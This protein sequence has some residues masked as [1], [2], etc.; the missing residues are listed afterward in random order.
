MIESNPRS[1]SLTHLLDTPK[2][3]WLTE[4]SDTL[5]ADLKAWEKSFAA[6]H[7]GR[8]AGRADIKYHVDI[9]KKYKE[10]NRVRDVLAGK[11]SAAASATSSSPAPKKRNAIGRPSAVEH[12]PHRRQSFTGT[13]TQASTPRKRSGNSQI[14]HPSNIDP[15]DVPTAVSAS[16]HTATKLYTFRQVIGPTPQ[17]D[18]KALGLFDLISTSGSSHAATPSSRKRKAD[19]L[20]EVHR[21]VVKTPSRKI[22][23][24]A[25]KE[26]RQQDLLAH[27][28]HESDENDA[29]DELGQV[30]RRHSRTPASEGKK[31]LLSQF[32]AT[33]TAA[34]FASD[35]ETSESRSK[36]GQAD[37]LDK[38]P[39]RTS[40][41]QNRASG[42]FITPPHEKLPRVPLQTGVDTTPSFLKRPSFSQ[43]LLSASSK[44][45]TALLS[46]SV[47]APYHK[48]SA[49]AAATATV[50][51][52]TSPSAVRQRGPRSLR[53]A[54]GRSLSQIMHN[55]RKM[56]D[57]QFE[58]DEEA[59]RDIE[60]GQGGEVRNVLV[61]DS[62]QQAPPPGVPLPDNGE[63]LGADDQA[64]AEEGQRV[65]KKKGQKRT[66]RRVNMRPSVAKPVEVP[67]WD[68]DMSD[69]DGVEYEEAGGE[70]ESEDELTAGVEETQFAPLPPDEL[71]RAGQRSMARKSI[72]TANEASQADDDD[73]FIAHPPPKTQTKKTKTKSTKNADPAAAATAAPERNKTKKPRMYNPNAVSHQNFRSL[74][75]KNKN[76]R[77][78]G[79]G[80]GGR[81]RG[82][83]R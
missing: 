82:G 25:G 4:K 74:K 41:L 37:C 48:D 2:R 80:F 26:Q 32:F 76:S 38:T 64:N 12:I 15:Y 33:P 13:Q 47:S 62:Q 11:V 69:E 56:E 35:V 18:G 67:K 20:Q 61:G 68:D 42:A 57:E 77:A 30:G 55:L 46:T 44:P 49:P 8:K 3:L 1:P 43:R 36:I 24:T 65:W 9:A 14:T 50:Q 78:K 60:S 27:L 52:F 21:N 63:S 66:T 31:F 51:P 73:E 54:S 34:R 45:S 75:I 39:L 28:D 19:A 5:R 7:D 23:A 10:Y 81:G 79:R 53:P 83:R 40:V 71:N 17:R 58:D 22:A 70:D 59:L 29:G 6:T 72:T 16:P